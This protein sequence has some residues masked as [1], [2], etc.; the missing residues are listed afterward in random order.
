MKTTHLI[1]S[2]LALFFYLPLTHAASTV[3]CD[4][5]AK[6]SGL[7]QGKSKGDLEKNDLLAKAACKTQYG[8]SCTISD[9]SKPH[10]DVDPQNSL[11]HC[12]KIK[13]GV[14]LAAMP[15][16]LVQARKE[17]RFLELIVEKWTKTDENGV[18][19][20]SY[21]KGF[22]KYVTEAN[23]KRKAYEKLA[24]QYVNATC[25]AKDGRFCKSLTGKN[26][27]CSLDF[28]LETLPAD[29]RLNQLDLSPFGK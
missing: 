13:M 8:W 3:E 23:T 1:G 22:E 18:I 20:R 15:N 17:L 26:E 2:F 11:A 12:G 29:P 10:C 4:A 9:F 24:N 27:L 14:T 7:T 28:D 19:L 25:K 21:S 6:V 5:E 16:E